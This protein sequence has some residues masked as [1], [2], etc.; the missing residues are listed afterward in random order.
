M[1]RVVIALLFGAVSVGCAG[2]ESPTSPTSLD[3]SG[4]WQGTLSAGAERLAIR[5]SLLQ[6]GQDV[7]GT[8]AAYETPEAGTGGPLGGRVN[9]ATLSISLHENIPASQCR[10]DVTATVSGR[11]M[12]GTYATFNCPGSAGGSIELSKV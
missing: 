8:W 4:T 6:N 3:V 1:I 10:L 2:T 11:R 7:T 5:L 9:G 12:V